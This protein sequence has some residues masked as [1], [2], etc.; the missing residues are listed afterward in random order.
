MAQ[1]AAREKV[2]DCPAITNNITLTREFSVDRCETA[3][4]G[5]TDDDNAKFE[6]FLDCYDELGTCEEDS[7][8]EYLSGWNECV[9]KSKG[10]TEACELQ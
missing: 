6:A 7:Q 5:C 1:V 9:L 8:Q 4:Q 3:S 10:A 2:E